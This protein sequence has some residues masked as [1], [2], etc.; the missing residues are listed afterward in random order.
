MLMI[1]KFGNEEDRREVP[2]GRVQ[3][4]GHILEEGHIEPRL[5]LEPAQAQVYIW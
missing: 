4:E 5:E 1:R 2:R 3:K